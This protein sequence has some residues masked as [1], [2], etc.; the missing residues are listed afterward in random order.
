M[1]VNY[2]GVINLFFSRTSTKA[3]DCKMLFSFVFHQNFSGDGCVAAV[4]V[5]G[6]GVGETG[7]AFFNIKFDNCCA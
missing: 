4:I 6:D 3:M 5:G 1:V 7:K 2:F